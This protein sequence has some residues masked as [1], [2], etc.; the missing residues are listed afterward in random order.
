MFN[1]SQIGWLIDLLRERY[2]IDLKI[3]LLGGSLYLY[4]ENITSAIVFDNP[5]EGFR[6]FGYSKLGCKQ[7]DPNEEGFID[8]LGCGI[9]SPGLGEGVV[10]ETVGG[11]T[12]CHYDILGLAYW[13]LNRL[14]EIGVDTLDNHGRY[15]YKESHAFRYGYLEF[16]IVDQWLD[17]LRQVILRSWPE[18]K[19]KEHKYE[20]V[21]THDVDRPSRYLFCKSFSQFFKFALYDLKVDKNLLAFVKSFWSYVNKEELHPFDPYNTFEWI[22]DVSERNNIISRFYFICGGD[23]TLDA[24][25]KITDSAIIRLIERITNRNHEI[26]LHP[27]YG[28]YLSKNMIHNEIRNLREVLPDYNQDVGGR[29]HYLRF[30][31]PDTLRNL[32]AAG[33]VYD[34]TLGYAEHIGFRCGTSFEYVP[35]DPVE[36]RIINIKII[37]L[38]FMDVTL[39]SYMGLKLDETSLRRVQELKRKCYIFGGRFTILWHN[40]NFTKLMQKEFYEKLFKL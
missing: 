5:N 20:M 36:N 12:Y 15:F 31:Y 3:D 13:C 29:M 11:N 2:S 14:E 26:G 24:D 6:T 22:M 27:S 19:L 18:I 4:N 9:S 21:V 30:K 16:P 28:T 17:I 39:Y 38:I 25:Y 35:F 10:F 8:L 37:P 23:T 7:W 32:V 40:S 1:Q 34:S 33:L